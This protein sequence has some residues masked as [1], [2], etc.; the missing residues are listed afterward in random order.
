[1]T[2]LCSPDHVSIATTGD[3]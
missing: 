1:M 2:A 3:R